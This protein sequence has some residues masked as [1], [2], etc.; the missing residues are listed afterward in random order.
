M[1]FWNQ[2]KFQPK[3]KS[4]FLLT[5]GGELFITVKSV[6]KP[7]LTIESQEYRMINHFYK[8]PTL[9]KWEPIDIVL[10]DGS[11]ED[12]DAHN[13]SLNTAAFLS[14]L[15]NRIGYV[16]N[17]QKPI[18]DGDFREKYESEGYDSITKKDSSLSFSG[19]G[20]KGDAIIK[21]QQ[22]NS[23]G[24]LIEEWSLF[25]PIIKSLEWG[26]L[27]YGSDDHVEYKLNLDYDYAKFK[28]GKGTDS[29]IQGAP[30]QIYKN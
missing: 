27:Q 8:F 17:D 22:V 4:R 24:K 29:P 26:D 13:T 20:N 11:G 7:K 10:V 21:I 30:G 18:D 6:S 1:T 19:D 3:S 25:N 2:P 12:E 28:S 16:N 9:A 23:N 5:L 14:A 15:S